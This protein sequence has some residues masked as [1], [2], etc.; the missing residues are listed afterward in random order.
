MGE[1][2]DVYIDFDIAT[3]EAGSLSRAIVID[4]LSTFG[5][6]P[7]VGVSLQLNPHSY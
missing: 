3:L 6:G 5:M 1:L 4:L 2:Q 7:E